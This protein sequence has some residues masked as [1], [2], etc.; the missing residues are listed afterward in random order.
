MK[1]TITFELEFDGDTENL[2]RFA[3]F[4]AEHEIVSART[5]EVV[6]KA[7]KYEVRVG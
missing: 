2:Y 4:V 3:E 7:R 6:V 1:A 5:D